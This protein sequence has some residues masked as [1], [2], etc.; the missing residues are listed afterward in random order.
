MPRK[1]V[2]GTQKRYIDCQRNPNHVFNNGEVELVIGQETYEGVTIQT[3]DG[4]A[5][6]FLTAYVH[7]GDLV[8]EI[9]TPDNQPAQTQNINFRKLFIKQELRAPVDL[10]SPTVVA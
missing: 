10:A 9:S 1:S 3:K 8:L 7:R 6:L 5:E 2:P 4:S